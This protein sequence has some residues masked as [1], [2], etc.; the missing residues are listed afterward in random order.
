MSQLLTSAI[1]NSHKQYYLRGRGCVPR[2]F[3]VQNRQQARP[4]PVLNKTIF[5]SHFIFFDADAT[6]D[7]NSVEISLDVQTEDLN[8]DF[9]P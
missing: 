7:S 9:T 6:L 4:S 2:N 5:H 8:F 3:Y 1:I